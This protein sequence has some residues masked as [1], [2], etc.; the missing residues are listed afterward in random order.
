[1]HPV[2]SACIDYEHLNNLVKDLKAILRRIHPDDIKKMEYVIEEMEFLV[3]EAWD[4]FNRRGGYELY[5]K[6]SFNK[7][8]KGEE[9]KSEKSKMMEA[10]AK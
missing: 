7:M 4:E 1:M 5:D 6:I 2:T 3:G 10:K 8:M 9:W